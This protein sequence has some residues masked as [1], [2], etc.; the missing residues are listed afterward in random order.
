MYPAGCYGEFIFRFLNQFD[1][2]PHL[3][4]QAWTEIPKH[5]KKHRDDHH[6][7][8]EDDVEGHVTKITYTNNNVDLINR[9]K[10]TKV[11]GHLDEQSEKTFPKNKNKKVYTM[12]IYKCLLLDDKNHFKKISIEGNTEIKFS[13]FL[14]NLQKWVENFSNLFDILGISV[15]HESIIK[16]HDIFLQSQKPIMEDHKTAKDEI[17][18]GN[19][20]GQV[21]FEKHGIDFS[22]QKFDEI[23]LTMGEPYGK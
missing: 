14:E 8:K 21:Y 18:L 17:Y 13:W 4:Y 5:T 2:L 15:K 7:I 3:S 12:A 22:E 19:K 23:Y 1:T 16:F 20:L 10:W 6:I 11:I 9:N